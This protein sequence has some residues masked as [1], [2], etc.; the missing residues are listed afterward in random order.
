[1]THVAEVL[2]FTTTPVH[3]T[4]AIERGIPAA[5]HSRLF[6]PFFTTKERGSGLGLPLVH[7][8]I[9]QH[10]GSIFVEKG[11]VGGARFVI[12]LP[13]RLGV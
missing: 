11:R 5:L 9:Q 12:K 7:S 6:E 8:V 2:E 1:M 3:A 10:G 4:P 13:L